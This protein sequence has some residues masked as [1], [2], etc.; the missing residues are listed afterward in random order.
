MNVK[1]C[2]IVTILS[3]GLLQACS[4][5]RQPAPPAAEMIEQPVSSVG[6]TMVLVE[7]AH[8]CHDE[9]ET[10]RLAASAQLRSMARYLAELLPTDQCTIHTVTSE[11]VVLEEAEG[12][13]K[14][15][16]ESSEI[17]TFDNYLLPA[18][19]TAA[20]PSPVLPAVSCC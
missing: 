11:V 6:S 7:Q 8:I 15:S 14:I 17:F 1:T 2:A 16:L 5:P 13:R 18:A 20:Q 10:R 12:Y 19:A 9:A 3:L 4:T